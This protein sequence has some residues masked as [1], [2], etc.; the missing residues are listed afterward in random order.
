MPARS[1]IGKSSPIICGVRDLADLPVTLTSTH[2]VIFLLTGNL[3]TLADTVA[4]I[5]A[6]QKEVFV[7]FDMVDGLG[8]DVHG[9]RWFAQAVR[10]T[11]IITTRAAIIGSAK[12]LG[13]VTVQRM[14]L[15]DSQSLQT[16]L[17]LVK[18]A[19]PDY[20]EV[21]PGIVPEALQEIVSR[22]PCPVIAGGLV[23]RLSEMQAALASGAIAVSTGSKDLWQY[24]HLQDV[25]GASKRGSSSPGGSN[26][27]P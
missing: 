1:L 13:L 16:G 9:L 7:H 4:T 11:G 17:H 8:K 25:K 6:H 19:K 23:K 21:M 26:V 27:G 14:F 24:R 3:S 12:S 10:P 22:V 18:D 20:L 15:L 5:R 2:D